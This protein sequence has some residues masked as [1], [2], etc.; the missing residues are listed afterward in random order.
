MKSKVPWRVKLERASH[1]H[2][3]EAP[4][5]WVGGVLG[6]KMLIPSA[7]EMDTWIR[8]IPAG[9][10]RTVIQMREHFA[11][12]YGADITCP[13]TSGIFL[14]IIAENAEEERAGGRKDVTPYWRVVTDNGRM[15][16]KIQAVFDLYHDQPES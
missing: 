10:T 7:L 1:P 4:P 8:Q 2:I 3:E 6:K 5:R 16:P 11:K 15:P 14:R 12:K 9:Q 13:M